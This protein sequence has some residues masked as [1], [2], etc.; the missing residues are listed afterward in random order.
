[1]TDGKGKRQMAR[2]G[3]QSVVGSGQTAWGRRVD[4]GLHGVGS[5]GGRGGG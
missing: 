1:M 4:G 3:V 2:A 5:E